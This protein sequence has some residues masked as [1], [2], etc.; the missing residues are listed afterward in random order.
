MK[1]SVG[2]IRTSPREVNEP[3]GFSSSDSS[4]EVVSVVGADAFVLLAL[5]M[6][7]AQNA[8]R[9]LHRLMMTQ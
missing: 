5:D 3:D 4:R 7:S 8:A 2:V 9:L 6:M 1:R